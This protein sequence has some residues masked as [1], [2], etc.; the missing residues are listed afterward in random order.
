MRL[1]F[2][3]ERRVT[4][5]AG[6]AHSHRNVFIKGDGKHVGMITKA[7]WSSKRDDWSIQLTVR[8][9]PT[10]E[11]PA[12]FKWI[13]L[14]KRAETAEELREFVTKHWDDI[15]GHYDLYQSDMEDY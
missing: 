1:T 7:H 11:A 9:E 15:R 8:K 14:K 4:G 3:L 5:L 10:K 6:V 12:D 2:K 13:T